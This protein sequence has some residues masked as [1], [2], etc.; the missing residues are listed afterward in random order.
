MEDAEYESVKYRGEMPKREVDKL[1]HKMLE[2]RKTGPKARKELDRLKTYGPYCDAQSII[3]TT[4]K[5]HG[6][7]C[8]QLA[9]MIGCSRAT[10]YLWENGIYRMDGERWEVIV[11]IFPEM[12]EHAADVLRK[13]KAAIRAR[14]MKNKFAYNLTLERYKANMTKENVANAI[15]V[16]ENTYIGW[17]CGRRPSKKNIEKLKEL[18]PGLKEVSP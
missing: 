17:E 7:S 15:G 14:R 16:S 6:I 10:V 11:K 5:A 2:E 1:R 3:R 12:K 4:R 9:E 13:Q 8:V 18:F